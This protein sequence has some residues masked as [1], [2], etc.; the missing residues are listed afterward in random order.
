MPCRLQAEVHDLN[1][2]HLLAPSA[3]V[4]LCCCCCCCHRRT[5][6]DWLP[7]DVCLGMLDCELQLSMKHVTFVYVS[8][9]L[10]EHGCS[11][12]C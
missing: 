8:A 10:C 3:A 1:A 7:V 12:A 11:A 4:L 5:K 6:A 2:P 9:V